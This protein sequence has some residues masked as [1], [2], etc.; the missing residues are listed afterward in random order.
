MTCRARGWV[1]STIKGKLG[2][3]MRYQSLPSGFVKGFH[4]EPNRPPRQAMA[5][6]LGAGLDTLWENRERPVCRDSEDRRGRR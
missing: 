3:W 4:D 2:M 1:F 6:G 5:V